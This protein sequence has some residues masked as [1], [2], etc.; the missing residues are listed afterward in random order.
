MGYLAVI[1]DLDV[2]VKSIFPN[3]YY[4]NQDKLKHCPLRDEVLQMN[5]D[6]ITLFFLYG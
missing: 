5:H 6:L 4:I 1:G 3:I 2:E